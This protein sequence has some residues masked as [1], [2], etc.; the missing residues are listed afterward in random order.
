MR[1]TWRDGLAT[2]LV[3]GAAVPFALWAAGAVMP[4]AGILAF[5]LASKVM[6]AAMVALWLIATGRHVVSGR[7]RQL[8]ARP[9]GH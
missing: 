8:R 9:A 5:V 6:L 7:H 4:G 2:L 1:L 3:A